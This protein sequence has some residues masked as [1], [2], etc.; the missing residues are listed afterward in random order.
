MSSSGSVS[1]NVGRPMPLH[2]DSAFDIGAP[3]TGKA[4][5]IATLDDIQAA[6]S[7]AGEEEIG[8]PRGQQESSGLTGILWRGFNYCW[9]KIAYLFACL[10][11]RVESAPESAEREIVLP[12]FPRRGREEVGSAEELPEV[13]PP[14]LNAE[15]TAAV[16][17]FCSKWTNFLTANTMPLKLAQE[18]ELAFKEWA[19]DLC[20]LPARVRGVWEQVFIPY[21]KETIRNLQGRSYHP[22]YGLQICKMTTSDAIRTCVAVHVADQRIMHVLR[23][24]VF[25][26]KHK[27]IIS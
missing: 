3:L 14:E 27:P 17:T 8:P 10:F 7:S 12:R 1:L 5:K 21:H 16:E 22:V 13:Q 4:A 18:N 20:G 11:G 2:V 24:T 26:N 25:S 6:I 15:E 9:E 19:D 23:E